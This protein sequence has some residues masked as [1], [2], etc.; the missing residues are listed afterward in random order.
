VRRGCRRGGPQ[1]IAG[2]TRV[3]RAHACRRALHRAEKAAGE[4]SA[5]P[6]WRPGAAGGG[7][8]IVAGM[9]ARLEPA[10]SAQP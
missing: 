8:H 3:R 1:P 5:A 10:G 6:G 7:E 4:M 2:D 9:S